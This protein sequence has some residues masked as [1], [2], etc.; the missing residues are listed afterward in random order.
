MAD[1]FPES[2]RLDEGRMHCRIIHHAPDPDRPGEKPRAELERQLFYALQ[3]VPLP[4]APD[5]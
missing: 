4:E 1:S 3:Q 5:A 2:E